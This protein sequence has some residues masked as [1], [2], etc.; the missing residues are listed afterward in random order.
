[1][2]GEAVMH[3]LAAGPPFQGLLVL[4][5]GTSFKRLVLSVSDY[6]TP[7]KKM[8]FMWI[9]GG[10]LL[11]LSTAPLAAGGPINQT[12]LPCP[13]CGLWV[14]ANKAGHRSCKLMLEEYWASEAGQICKETIKHTNETICSWSKSKDT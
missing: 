7:L 10:I 14:E 12:A 5:T 1:M 9:C 3:C 2:V 6:F 11:R 13:G 4:P 8:P